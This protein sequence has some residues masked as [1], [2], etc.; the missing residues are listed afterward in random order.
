[1]I[2]L[3]TNVRPELLAPAPSVAVETW[4]TE[5]QTAAEFTTTVTE[6]E[7]FYGLRLMPDGRRR[8]ELEAAIVPIFREDLAGRILPFGS[9]AADAFGSIAARRR[10][11]GRP[12]S[13]FDAQIAAIAWSRGASVAY[14]AMSRISLRP[15]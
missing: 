5:Q 3:D 10:K 12:I 7:L 2:I 13:Q 4:L 6:A 9:E 14:P 8:Q 1:M 15:V 11:L